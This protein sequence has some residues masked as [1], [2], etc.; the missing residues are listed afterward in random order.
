LPYTYKGLLSSFAVQ[1]SAAPL[2][3]A[4]TAKLVIS[5]SIDP[6]GAATLNPFHITKTSYSKGSDSSGDLT[7]TLLDASGKTLLTYR[8]DARAIENSGSVTFNELVPWNA[9]TKQL[10][11]KRQQTVLATRAVSSNKPTVRV[12]RPAAGETWGAKATVSWQASDADNDPLTYTV[13]YNSGADQ[14]WVPIATGVTDH[15]T[16]IDTALLAGST[17]A[18]VRVRATDGVNSTDADSAEF[19]VPG[20]APVVTILGATE[21]KQVDR[22]SAEFAGAA[23]D[24][25]EGLVPAARMQWTSDRDGLLGSGR[26]IKVTKPLSTGVHVITLTVTNAQGLMAS[27]KFTIVAE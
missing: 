24:P 12:M 20:H 14:R 17:R 25:Q 15:S 18:R 4:V 7:L 11:L 26:Q 21:R 13:L 5:G 23:Y 8:F 1:E 6:A 27:K 10:V 22:N 16:T 2:Q 19:V 9:Q 3:S